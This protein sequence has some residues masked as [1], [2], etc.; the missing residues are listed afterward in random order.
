MKRLV[1]RGTLVTVC[2]RDRPNWFD[3]FSLITNGEIHTLYT[4]LVLQYKCG[5]Y[6]AG[7]NRI[8]ATA[9]FGIPGYY[10]Q[11]CIAGAPQSSTLFCYTRRTKVSTMTFPDRYSSTEPHFGNADRRYSGFWCVHGEL[12]P[13]NMLKKF[14]QLRPAWSRNA[15]VA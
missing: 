10:R 7:F 4:E 3:L 6:P 8:Q 13:Q 9:D 1:G 2:A 5:G 12:V 15:H 14:Y 11:P